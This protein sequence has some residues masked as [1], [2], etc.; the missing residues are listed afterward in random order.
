MKNFSS[1]Q[2]GVFVVCFLGIV[3]GVLI[4][5]GKIPLGQSSSTAVTGSVTV[6]GTLPYRAVSAGLEPIR[7]AYKDVTINYVE[8][9]PQEFQPDFIDA[10]ASGVGPDLVVITPAD[11]IQDKNKLMLV[12]FTSLP[13]ATFR[14]TF[15]DQGSLFLDTTGVVAFPLFVDP[16]IMYY[17]RDMLTSLFVVQPPATW[18][19]VVDLNKK[20]T[21]KDSAG[22]LSIETV[23]LGTFD[24]ITHAKDLIS[25]LMLQSGSKIID[26]SSDLNKYV[27][28][29]ANSINGSYPVVNALRFYISFANS[30][31]AD[32]YSWGASLP[33]DKDQFVAGN[34]ATYFGYASELAGIRQRN[35]NLNFDIA[36][37][38][39]RA[40]SSVKATYGTLHG[41]AIVKSS[42]NPSL[43]VLMA[44]QMASKDAIDAYLA[45]DPTFVPARKDMLTNPPADD[46]RKTLLYNSAIISRSWIDPDKVQTT[47]VFQKMIQQ[48]NAGTITPESTL[49]TVGSLLDSILS[50]YQKSSI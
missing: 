33:K 12:P 2:I 40:K 18:D 13:E 17:N 5:S 35:P 37:M 39:Q 47:S 43:A 38:P 14:S 36:L 34:L 48:I 45:I 26:F 22:K 10:L 41:V 8:K 30:A 21:Q 23:A 29:F 44:Q 32:H 25:L 6:W 1:F 16:M 31:D 20:N 15:I 24:N 46:S 4:F 27:S 9:D 42:K 50:K 11:I 3:F 49:S 7:K 19:D 28:V